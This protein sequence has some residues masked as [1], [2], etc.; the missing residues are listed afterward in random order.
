MP[1]M[2]F[3]SRLIGYTEFFDIDKLDYCFITTMVF[4]RSNIIAG[5]Q[6]SIGALEEQCNM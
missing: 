3:A 5:L 4:G 6:S 2:T 1:S